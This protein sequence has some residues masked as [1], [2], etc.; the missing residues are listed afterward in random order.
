MRLRF[1]A[2]AWFVLFLLAAGCGGSA[3]DGAGQPSGSG[4]R[5]LTPTARPHRDRGS[6]VLSGA[7]AGDLSLD[8]V[9]CAPPGATLIVGIMGKVGNTLYGLQINTVAAGSYQ[10][11]TAG[12]ANF[13]ALVLLMDEAVSQGSVQRWSAGFADYPGKGTLSIAQDHSGAIDAE[14]DGSPGTKGTVHVKGNW[15]C[16]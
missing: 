4:P 10:F 2:L 8:T 12:T 13:Q 14:L 6:I 1:F 7:I 9:I 5:S 16:L 3:H 15:T 11:G